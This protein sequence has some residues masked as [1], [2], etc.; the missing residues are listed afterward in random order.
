GVDF[1]PVAAL[2]T[3]GPNETSK[4]IT[5][6]VAADVFVEGNETV[7]LQLSSPTNGAS[8]GGAHAEL[9]LVDLP[10]QPSQEI[11]P[12]VRVTRGRKRQRA[13]GTVRQRIT[14]QNLDSRGIYG[15]LSLVLD[16]LSKKVK[17]RKQTGMTH[18][19]PFKVVSLG[20]GILQAG[21]TRSVVLEFRNP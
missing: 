11:T 3:F 20:D 17:L 15:P 18:G 13:D 16:Q 21:E 10:A 14:I 7:Q 5:I 1:T 6:P 19:S 8:L 9:T 4:T 2:L 12:L